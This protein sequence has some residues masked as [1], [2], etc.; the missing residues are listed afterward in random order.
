MQRENKEE[1]A[2]MTRGG[3][4]EE[5]EIY[6]PR[7]LPPPPPPPRLCKY[8]Y[9]KSST[10]TQTHKAGEKEGWKG[11]KNR[12]I[13]LICT[14]VYQGQERELFFA[15]YVCESRL[16]VYLVRKDCARSAPSCLL[17]GIYS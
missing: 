4:K 7:S 17:V 3:D 11:E 12:Q 5:E 2:M 16:G 6:S 15:G 14:R 9:P 10:E 13:N 1:N 8:F